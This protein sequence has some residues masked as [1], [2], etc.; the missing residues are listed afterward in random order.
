MQTTKLIVEGKELVNISQDAL[1]WF[2][3]Q[4]LNGKPGPFTC[5]TINSKTNA[6]LLT[7][8]LTE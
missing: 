7:V 8:K 4:V 6:I 1:K 5:Q 3:K 2:Y